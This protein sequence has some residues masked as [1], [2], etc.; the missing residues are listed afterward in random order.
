MSSEEAGGCF[1]A[2]IAVGMIV[3]IAYLGFDVSR[4]EAEKEARTEEARRTL[5]LDRGGYYI[6][7]GLH[8]P[9]AHTTAYCIRKPVPV[10][11]TPRN[12]AV[13]PVQETPQ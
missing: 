4:F 5:C 2:L 13:Q 12:G 9:S 1:I 10:D 6:E 3:F 11:I 8:I 7:S